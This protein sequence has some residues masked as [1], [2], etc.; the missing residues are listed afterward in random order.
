MDCTDLI[1]L[2][3]TNPLPNYVVAKYFSKNKNNPTLQRIWLVHSEEKNH[4]A[5]TNIQAENLGGILK[6]QPD[7]N[8]DIFMVALSD[9]S[10]A[11]AI[12][13]DINSLLIRHESLPKGAS[14]HLN[15]TG[16]TKVMGVH[17]YHAVKQEEQKNLSKSY[18]YLD[19]RNFR[20]VDD[21][22]RVI[23]DDLRGEISISFEEMIKLHGF[24]RVNKASDPGFSLA[25]EGFITLVNNNRLNDYYRIDNGGYNRALFVREEKGYEK[26]THQLAMRIKDLKDDLRR[27]KPKGAFLSIVNAMP[28]G[29]RFF[30]TSGQF[31]SP[32][33]DTHCD[34]AIKFLDG[35]WLEEYVYTVLKKEFKKPYSIDKNWEIQKENWENTKNKFQLDVL[36]LRGYQLTGVSCTT[37]TDKSLCKSKGF[38]IIHRTRQIGGDE[39]KAIILTRLC[40]EPT[41]TLQEEL[42]VDTGS[43][44]SNILALGVYDWKE[45]MLK[46][47]IQ[48]FLDGG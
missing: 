27:Y 2:I 42:T 30:D 31:V 10:N 20:I 35:G 19:G 13:S 41:E 48:Q 36:L 15:Y 25:I 5:G 38:E 16:G 3:G 22:G 4:Q 26:K 11:Q 8:K 7:F 24:S 21:S 43:T 46:K 37:S 23:A 45:D 17:V 39:A 34:H 1:L 12:V 28:E 6:K 47:K 40:N 29:Y 33:M 9:V 14:V 32:T 44:S 18:S